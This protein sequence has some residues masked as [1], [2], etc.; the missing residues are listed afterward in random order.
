[1]ERYNKDTKA[2]NSLKLFSYSAR[3]AEDLRRKIR[4][5]TDKW[6]MGSETVIGR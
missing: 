2:A 5:G 1:M 6:V 3:Q 4:K